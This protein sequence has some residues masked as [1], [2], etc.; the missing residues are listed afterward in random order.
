MNTHQKIVL[1][2]ALICLGLLPL[3]TVQAAKIG[4]NSCGLGL[5]ADPVPNTYCD[6]SGDGDKVKIGKDSCNVEGACTSLG[7]NL[8]IGNNSCN[9]EVACQY[10]GSSDGEANLL[11]ERHIAGISL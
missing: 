10:A 9:A 11:D 8:K 6:F 1:V 5:G 3:S 2:I 4:K 7:D